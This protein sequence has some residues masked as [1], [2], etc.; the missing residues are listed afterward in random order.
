M[1]PR[2]SGWSETGARSEYLLRCAA[3]CVGA[4]P[5]CRAP[6][7]I[8]RLDAALQAALQAAAAP[9]PA[10]SDVAVGDEAGDGDDDESDEY[11]DVP[12]DK[13]CVLCLGARK[14]TTVT[15]CG[16][17]L[18]WDCVTEWCAAKPVC[19][20]CRSKAEPHKLVRLYNYD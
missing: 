8:P 4:V 16:H 6:P 12:D 3:E 7:L 18:C 19:P 11:E 5:S 1:P 9:A 13:K 15:P 2:S 20:V 14:S 17:L 10:D